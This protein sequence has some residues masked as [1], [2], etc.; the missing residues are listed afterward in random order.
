M[1]QTRARWKTCVDNMAR[2]FMP[3]AVG[4]L[5][6]KA[7]FTAS[8]KAKVG[9]TTPLLTSHHFTSHDSQRYVTTYITASAEAKVSSNASL[10]TSHHFTS[11]DGQRYVT[12]YIT[13]TAE[14]NV[15]QYYVI[16]YVTSYYV[17]SSTVGQRYV[18]IHITATTK[19]KVGS[20]TLLLTSH[21]LRHIL[22]CWPE[23]RH[24]VHHPHFQG[25]GK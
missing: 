20:T 25:K 7:Y 9:S 11:H 19:A 16:A 4:Q 6:A 22:P 5:Y 14:A 15:R 24:Q 23:L 18:A 17:T 21:I 8:A 1:T 3:T 2:S 10:L 12:T 13:A